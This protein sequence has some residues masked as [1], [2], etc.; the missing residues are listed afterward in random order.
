MVVEANS[1]NL[2][3]EAGM[4]KIEE[5]LVPDE[6]QKGRKLKFV[7]RFFSHSIRKK[8]RKIRWKLLPAHRR[9]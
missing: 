3:K 2:K 4:N 5:P 6:S 9:K 1:I 8:F 7:R